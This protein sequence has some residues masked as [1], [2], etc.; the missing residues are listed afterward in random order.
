MVLSPGMPDSPPPTD[1]EVLAAPV[2]DA[3]VLAPH[4]DTTPPV[5]ELKLAPPPEEAAPPAE[6]AEE[7]ATDPEKWIDPQQDWP[8]E[9][10][11]FMGDRLAVRKPTQQALAALSLA[12]NEFSTETRRTKYITLFVA[13][14]T[15]E[16]SWDRVFDRMMNPDDPEYTAD[17]VSDFIKMVASA[18][19]E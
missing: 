11:E 12:T 5:K 3:D 13:R 7:P 4:P 6:E 16:G 8:Y 18:E 14:H 17:S 1:A 9:W 19:T 2:N 10:R 15:S